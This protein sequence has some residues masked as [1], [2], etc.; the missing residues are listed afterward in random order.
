M[1]EGPATAESL[2]V[3]D[4]RLPPAARDKASLDQERKVQKHNATQVGT[5]ESLVDQSD[6]PQDRERNGQGNC[7]PMADNQSRR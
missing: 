7:P 5:S 6:K 2:R 4:N 3:T 1:L